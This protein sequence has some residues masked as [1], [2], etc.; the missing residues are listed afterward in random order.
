MLEELSIIVVDDMHYSRTV[1]EQTLREAGYDDVR[2]ASCGEEVLEMLNR[3]AADVLLADWVM[4]GMNGLELTSEIRRKGQQ[5]G[6]YTSIILFSA[7]E[8]ETAFEEAFRR[9]IDDFI[10]KP[11]RPFELL[12]RVYAAGRTSRLHNELLTQSQALQVIQSHQEP[13]ITQDLLTG[14]NN[15]RQLRQHL[16]ATLM[17]TRNRGGSSC[18]AI[19]DID[20]LADINNTHGHETGDQVLIATARR[21]KRQLRPLDFIA[22]HQGDAF[23]LVLHSENALLSYERILGRLQENLNHRPVPVEAGLINVT[24]SVG[25]WCCSQDNAPHS[26]RDFEQLALQAMHNNNGSEPAS[27]MRVER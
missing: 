21:L 27:R 10:H 6:W 8:G 16:Q 14:L 4:P 23:A 19:F 25:A 2:T 18:L 26:A 22:R 5:E 1:I 3:R 7:K 20:H 24:C 12:A 15:R 17:Q 13:L 11:V 9:G